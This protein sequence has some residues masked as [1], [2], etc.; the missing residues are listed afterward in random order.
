[1]FEF[2]CGKSTN[3]WRKLAFPKTCGR[4]GATTSFRSSKPKTAWHCSSLRTYLLENCAKQSSSMYAFYS[5][6]CSTTKRE[7]SVVICGTTQEICS[8]WS[9]WS[10]QA[11][12]M[13]TSQVHKSAALSM[14]DIL[15]CKLQFAIVSVAV[16]D[17]KRFYS[18]DASAMSR[19]QTKQ[20]SVAPKDVYGPHYL[21]ALVVNKSPAVYIL[22]RALD[23]LEEKT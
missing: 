14:D 13:T 2:L 20:V 9:T 5:L 15:L 17:N 11:C 1:M 19:W 21:L 18:Q 6:H 10:T 23:G 8:T 22:S 3:K 16:G 7:W 4:T 12:S